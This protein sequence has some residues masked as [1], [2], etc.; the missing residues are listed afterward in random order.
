MNVTRIV[1]LA[2]TIGFAAL[3]LSCGSGTTTDTDPL[4]G[5]AIDSEGGVA[6]D[7]ANGA[8][9]FVPG[10]AI[11]GSELRITVDE[12]SSEGM[13]DAAE[14]LGDV[15]EFGPDGTQFESP[16]TIMLPLPGGANEASG[17]VLVT[18][19]AAGDAWEEIAGS[20]VMGGRVY[21]QTGHFSFY[22][23]TVPDSPPDDCRWR[24]VLPMVVPDSKVVSYSTRTETMSG[25]YDG[26]DM[27]EVGSTWIASRRYVTISGLAGPAGTGAWMDYSRQNG[28]TMTI[29]EDGTFEIE[30]DL[31][32]QGPYFALT[33]A[34]L[35]PE[36]DEQSGWLYHIQV[37]CNQD[38]LDDDGIYEDDTDICDFPATVTMA[39]HSSA[40]WYQAYFAF[41]PDGE[42]CGISDEILGVGTLLVVRVHDSGDRTVTALGGAVRWKIHSS[43]HGVEIT[44]GAIYGS[45]PD[46]TDITLEMSEY[47][48]EFAT[49]ELVMRF[50][51]T[52]FTVVSFSQL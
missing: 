32:N 42:L 43:S 52:E 25:G 21:G 31:H 4:P 15:Y 51:G 41:Y 1:R 14:L 23:V 10:G 12:V 8:G 50:D 11:A 46:A 18:L 9:V 44:E 6:W 27:I 20:Y 2:A 45:L 5:T 33:D 19:N 34:C 3:A 36:A 29:E 28:G 24:D 38:C 30:L 26:P 22:G 47:S 40:D 7:V 39:R 35:A 13:P 17:A 37:H 16:V 49:H 48:G